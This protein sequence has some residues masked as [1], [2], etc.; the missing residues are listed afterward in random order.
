MVR[1]LFLTLLY[2]HSVCRQHACDSAHRAPL[3]STH[4]PKKCNTKT[5]DSLSPSACNLL[6]TQGVIKHT[7]GLI[8]GPLHLVYNLSGT[9]RFLLEAANS[10][11]YGKGIHYLRYRRQ[12][13]GEP[14]SG[15]PRDFN[16]IRQCSRSRRSH[17]RMV[18]SLRLFMRLYITVVSSNE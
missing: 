14:K 15:S 11:C 6:F 5:P 2:I 3:S 7:E 4:K 10:I 9:Q 13:T 18:C 1:L 16:P 8:E 12:T 17:A